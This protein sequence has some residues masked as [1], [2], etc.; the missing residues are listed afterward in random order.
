MKIEIGESLVYTWLRHVKQCQM[1]QTNWTPSDLWTLKHQS[2]LDQIMNVVDQT[3]PSYAIFGHKKKVSIQQFI[4]QAEIDVMG[5]LDLG[6]KIFAVDVAF[7]EKGLGYG[8]SAE[9]AARVLKKC[10]RAAMCIYGYFDKKDAEVIFVSPKIHKKD[11]PLI[12]Q[13]VIDLE[14]QLNNMGYSFVF[15][16]VCDQSTP[17]FQAEI[18]DPV[19]GAINNISDT[20]ELFV[21]SIQLL[22]MF[23]N[24]SPIQLAPAVGSGSTPPPVNP[25]RNLQTYTVNG[26][27]PFPKGKVAKEAVQL[28]SNM[29]PKKKGA[30]IVSDWSSLKVNVPHF[31]ETRADFNR[32]IAATTDPRAS[33]RSE[34]IQL[35]NGD[36]I[37][38]SNQYTPSRIQS[39]IAEVNAR[40]WGITIA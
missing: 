21:R 28:Y 4:A 9:N 32:R 33:K 31:I 16:V 2:D 37:Y 38:V 22:H 14:H 15:K 27:G 30:A 18:L 17:D 3:F 34:R 13:S 24:S 35:P 11:W 40:P 12:D 5:S 36:V 23:Y 19:L 10:L 7:H 8:N 1:V 20:N 39:L 25:P 29:N 26:M 6:N